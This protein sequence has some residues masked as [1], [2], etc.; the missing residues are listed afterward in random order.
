MGHVCKSHSQPTNKPNTYAACTHIVH[1]QNE[2]SRS[3]RNRQTFSICQIHCLNIHA[4]TR[5]HFIDCCHA[6]ERV[7]NPETDTKPTHTHI[8]YTRCT[9]CWVKESTRTICGQIASG[10][11][12]LFATM[13][14]CL[15]TRPPLSFASPQCCQSVGTRRSTWPSIVVHCSIHTRLW[16]VKFLQRRATLSTQLTPARKC[17]DVRLCLPPTTPAHPNGYFTAHISRRTKWGSELVPSSLIVA[18]YFITPTAYWTNVYSFELW[19]VVYTRFL[20]ACGKLSMWF[21]VSIVDIEPVIRLNISSESFSW[22]TKKPNTHNK[23]IHQT[24]IYELSKWQ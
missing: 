1:G 2:N 7:S 18:P 21:S 16:N 14:V 20:N 11:L 10:T 24:K 23:K 12:Q 17:E 9:V 3:T 8:R 6:Y 15:P 13:A 19:K 5:T 4:L 22:A